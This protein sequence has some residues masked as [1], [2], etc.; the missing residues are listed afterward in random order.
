MLYLMNVMSCSGFN[1]IQTNNKLCNI[2]ICTV[3]IYLSYNILP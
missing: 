2:D 3:E 1:C